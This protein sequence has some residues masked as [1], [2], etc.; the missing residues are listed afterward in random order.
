M[1]G[2]WYIVNGQRIGPVSDDD[3]YHLLAG[4]TLTPSTFVWKAGMEEWRAAAEVDA[5]DK[6]FDLVPPQV[7]N[8]SESGGTWARV[9]THLGSSATLVLGCLGFVGGLSAVTKGGTGGTLIG[10]LVMILGALAYR[11]AKKRKL[12]EVKST[13]TRLI[14]EITMLLLIIL[15]IVLQNDLKQLIVTDPIPNA[16]IPLW[17]ILAYLIILAIPKSV[18]RSEARIK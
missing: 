7:P 4:N 6:M 10:A 14:S 12:G 3:L 5:L 11:S 18:M 2:W 9:R 1:S 15:I 13:A 8:V 17:A 16:L